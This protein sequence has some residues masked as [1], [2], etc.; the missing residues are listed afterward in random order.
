M[1]IQGKY[2]T[3]DQFLVSFNPT[4]Q[5]DCA[6]HLDRVF[7]GSSPILSQ[8]KLAYDEKTLSSW[9]EIH[10]NDLSE[11]AGVKVKMEKRQ[12]IELCAII[13]IEYWYLKVSEVLYFFYLF[14]SGRFGDFYGVVDPIRITTA[15]REYENIRNEHLRLISRAKGWE[16]KAS[17]DNEFNA[18]VKGVVDSAIKAIR[19]LGYEV[20]QVSSQVLKFEYKK[21]VVVFNPFYQW[22]Y[23]DTIKRGRGIE[24]LLKQ[25]T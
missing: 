4:T 21:S 10:I 13:E 16:A 6:R 12:R 24:N 15:L 25:L 9:L 3:R 7:D 11:F 20:K 1:K 22:F 23:G 5:V 17:Q 2:G 14:K 8:V 18:E 19:E